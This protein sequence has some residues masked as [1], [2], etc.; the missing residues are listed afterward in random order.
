MDDGG[1]AEPATAVPLEERDVPD[2]D[3]VGI[4]DEHRDADH[5]AGAADLKE[6][7]AIEVDAYV[8]LRVVRFEKEWEMSLPVEARG[9]QGNV[10]HHA[11]QP[12]N[13]RVDRRQISGKRASA[14][15]ELNRDR[16]QHRSGL[17]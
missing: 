4:T 15:V 10:R 3:L 7:A 17:S 13:P 5:P 8:L 2:L 12:S 1:P 14:P 6:L 16:T 11:D 9:D